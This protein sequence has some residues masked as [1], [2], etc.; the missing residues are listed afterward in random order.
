M[1]QFPGQKWFC[2]GWETCNTIITATDGLVK[3]TDFSLSSWQRSDWL[4]PKWHQPNLKQF[5]KNLTAV[6]YLASK[7]GDTGNLR[8]LHIH[9]IFSLSVKIVWCLQQMVYMSAVVE[10]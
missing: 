4:V 5:M 10:R 2:I 1:V 9:F 6:P 7:K 3:A 8:H